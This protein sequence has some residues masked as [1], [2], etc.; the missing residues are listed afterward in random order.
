[1]INPFPGAAE[2]AYPPKKSKKQRKREAKEV[3][4]LLTGMIGDMKCTCGEWKRYNSTI[5]YLHLDTCEINTK[6]NK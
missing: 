1:M 2:L 4:K 3:A 6:R 5:S